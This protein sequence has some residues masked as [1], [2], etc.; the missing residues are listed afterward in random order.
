MRAAQHRVSRD[1]GQAPVHWFGFCGATTGWPSAEIWTE[2]DARWTSQHLS[3]E[4]IVDGRAGCPDG[5]LVRP[6]LWRVT[7]Y[8]YGA[9]RRDFDGQSLSIAQLQGRAALPVNTE[10][11]LRPAPL[12]VSIKINNSALREIKI[13]AG[14]TI[15][16]MAD[17]VAVSWWAPGPTEDFF[18]S[19]IDLP[20]NPDAQ[21]I[22]VNDSETTSIE[23]L[24]Y[25]EI[26]R[27]EA[28]RQQ[29]QDFAIL[30]E[31]Y[32]TPNGTR[33]NFPVPAGARRVQISRDAAGAIVAGNFVQSFF[34][35][36]QFVPLG[37]IPIAARASDDVRFG[38]VSHLITPVEFL[39]E[40]VTWTLRWEIAP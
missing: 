38:N 36:V 32:F 20:Y 5:E 40:D 34:D 37:I 1:A 10:R 23:G 15:Y 21:T 6:G 17:D 29:G 22:P 19:W 16:V 11:M 31:T 12:W 2:R 13:D 25:C 27:V 24:L 33:G 4:R 39:A 28:A 26:A 9:V 3:C 18:G 7:T 30:T 8:G 14:Q 35:G